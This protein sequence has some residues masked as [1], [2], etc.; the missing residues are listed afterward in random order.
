MRSCGRELRSFPKPERTDVHHDSRFSYLPLLQCEPSRKPAAR[1]W[2]RAGLPAL[3][4][5]V[6]TSAAKATEDEQAANG[7]F[8]PDRP[9]PGSKRVAAYVLSLMAVMAGIGFAFA[10]Y[11]TA[12]RRSRDR[13]ADQTEPEMIRRVVLTPAALPGLGYIPGDVNILLGLNVAEA[14]GQ[15]D[16][17]RF[18]HAVRTLAGTAAGPKLHSLL[19]QLWEQVDHLILGVRVEDKLLPRFTL[20]VRSLR[21]IDKEAVLRLLKGQRKEHGRPLD[22]Y[23]PARVGRPGWHSVDCRRSYS[24][25]HPRPGRPRSRSAQTFAGNRSVQQ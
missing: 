6:A 13:M 4:G 2:P 24:G 16:S 18:L 17:L 22:L 15:E 8:D 25:D 12:T 1:A 5:S 11:T 19:T 9:R 14:A 21:T 7:R 10:W 3:P 23:V 20:V